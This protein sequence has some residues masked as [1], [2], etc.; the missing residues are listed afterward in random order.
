MYVSQFNPDYTYKNSATV[1]VKASEWTNIIAGNT[2]GLDDGTYIIQLKITSTS[3]TAYYSGICSWIKA[4][5]SAVNTYSEIPL[6]AVQKGLANQFYLR[7]AI[8]GSGI[9]L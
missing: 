2:T 9:Y 3:N 7:T 1:T 4:T 6:H 5:S 8:D